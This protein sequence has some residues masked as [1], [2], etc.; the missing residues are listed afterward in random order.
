MH[1][2]NPLNA[3]AF[4]TT[5]TWRQHLTLTLP[6]CIWELFAIYLGTG[7]YLK[8]EI[9]HDPDHKLV[10]IEWIVWLVGLEPAEL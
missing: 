7:Y 9:V 3:V 5:F 8:A 2:W 1:P 6:F 10:I 4:L